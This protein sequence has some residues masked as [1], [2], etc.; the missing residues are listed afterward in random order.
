MLTSYWAQQSS[1]KSLKKHFFF[2]LILAS[3]KLYC[4]IWY[5]Y[6]GDSGV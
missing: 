1:I 4:M 3:L 5:C 2:W 6:S